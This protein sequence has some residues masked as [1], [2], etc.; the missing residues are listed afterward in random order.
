MWYSK[1]FFINILIHIVIDMYE[2]ETMPSWWKNSPDHY[3]YISVLPCWMLVLGIHSNGFRTTNRTSG[4][5]SKQIGFGFIAPKNLF[6]IL[7][8]S[9]FVLLNDFQSD[10]PILFSGGEIF[11]RD[12]FTQSGE[13]QDEVLYCIYLPRGYIW[14]P[15]HYIFQQCSWLYQRSAS[16]RSTHLDTESFYLGFLIL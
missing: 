7:D 14:W 4:I 1:M 13:H 9:R 8:C 16:F 5:T 11:C 3:W 10:F 12:P 15:S 2:G 6:S